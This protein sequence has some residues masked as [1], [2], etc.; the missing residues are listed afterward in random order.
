MTTKQYKY[1]SRGFNCDVTASY[2]DGCLCALVIESPAPVQV[3]RAYFYTSEEKFIQAC[4]ENNINVIDVEWDVTFED[5]YN[6]YNYKVDKQPAMKYWDKMPKEKRIR[7]KL[8]NKQYD[9]QL[10]L[11]G[12]SKK[13]P[14]TYLRSEIYM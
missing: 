5:W 2:I 9:R 3:D 11:S 14:L 1:F 6:D 8:F 13:Y 10:K 4:K 7:A 12:L